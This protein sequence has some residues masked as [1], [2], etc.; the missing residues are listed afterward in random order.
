MKISCIA[1]M[2]SNNVIGL[3]N[4]M[5]WHLP[6]DLKHFKS[7]T[8]SKPIIMGRK[9]F[10]SI[11]RPLPGRTNIVITRNKGWHADGVTN[12]SSLSDAIELARRLPEA[13]DEIMIIGGGQ[14]Y[15]EAL[16]LADRLYITEISLETEG[17]AFFPKI[18]QSIW[19][20]TAR[21]SHKSVDGR[22][23]HAFINYDR[24]S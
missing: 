24:I 19:R 22:P 18:D 6:A 4:Q 12:A 14:V 10:E 1:A 5:P 8:L 11:G 13:V 2:A 16:P 17:D 7:I 23:A 3:N 21:E 9:T 15:K 20:E